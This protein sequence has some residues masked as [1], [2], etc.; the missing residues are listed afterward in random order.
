MNERKLGIIGLFIIYLWAAI[1]ITLVWAN[2]TSSEDE[3]DKTIKVLLAKES[4]Q[5]AEL[6]ADFKEQ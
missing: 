1:C 6:Q 2:S 5:W 4:K 3:F